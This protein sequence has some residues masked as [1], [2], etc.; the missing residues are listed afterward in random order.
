[1]VTRAGRFGVGADATVYGIAPDMA[2]YYAGSRS[3]HVFMRWRPE[4][5]RPPAHLH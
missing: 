4:V 3:F 2:P 5:E 1:V